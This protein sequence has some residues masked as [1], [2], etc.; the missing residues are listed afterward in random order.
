MPLTAEHQRRPE[1]GVPRDVYARA[2]LREQRIHSRQSFF[3]V[4]VFRVVLLD[5]P[6]LGPQSGS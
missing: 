3:G 4:A 2:N 1:I 6:G 5:P